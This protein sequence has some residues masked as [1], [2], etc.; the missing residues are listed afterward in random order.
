MYSPIYGV[1]T[2]RCQIEDSI[3][4]I[5]QYLHCQLLHSNVH[6]SDFDSDLI[7]LNENHLTENLR[8]IKLSCDEDR[9][10]FELIEIQTIKNSK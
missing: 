8:M 6:F 9:R 7:C 2:V 5:F 4:L 10:H 3:I 1:V